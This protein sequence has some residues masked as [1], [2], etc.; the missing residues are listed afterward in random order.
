MIRRPPRSTLFP[1]TTLFRSPTPDRGGRDGILAELPARGVDAAD[2]RHP[3]ERPALDQLLCWVSPHPAVFP[4]RAGS[5]YPLRHADR[6]RCGADDPA[7]RGA[8]AGRADRQ[9][10]V[11]SGRRIG[12]GDC[13]A[14]LSAGSQIS[15]GRGAVCGGGGLSRGGGGGGG[16]FSPP[17]SPPTPPGVVAPPP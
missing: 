7:R 6:P 1:Y 10:Q 12:G 14:D 17:P 4:P 5:V 3:G 11:R 13:G 2:P 15:G 8:A 9:P 16:A